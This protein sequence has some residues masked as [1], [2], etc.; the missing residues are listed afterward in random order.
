M[1]ITNKTLRIAA[2]R[3]KVDPAETSG[4]LQVFPPN[5]AGVGAAQT[6]SFDLMITIMDND[7]PQEMRIGLC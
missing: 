1:Y 2:L 6:I 4:I 5:Q 3:V 7:I